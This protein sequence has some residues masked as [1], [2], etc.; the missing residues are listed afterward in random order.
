MDILDK[1][2]VAPKAQNQAPAPQAQPPGTP[3]DSEE[4]RAANSKKME[5]KRAENEKK[6]NVEAG[7]KVV[8]DTATLECVLCTNPKGT[9]KVNYDTPTIQDK[10]TATIKERGPKSLVFLGNC[11][12]SPNAAAPCTTVMNVR[13]WKDVGT[14]LSQEQPV[15]LQK[16]TIPC[17]YGGVDITITDSGQVHQPESI[18]AVGAPVP[19][20]KEKINGN[21]Y[22]YNGTFEGSVKGQKIGKET[23][24]YAC[25]GKGSEE[26]IYKSPRKLKIEH[27]EFQKVCNIIKHEGLSSEKEEYLYIAHTNYNEA[28]RVGKTMFELLNS[29]YSSVDAKDKVEMKTSEKDTI[30][31]YSR[32]GAIDALLRDV[33]EVKNDPTDNATQWDGEDFL[34]W[35]IDTDLKPDSKTKYGHNKF[36]E[37]DYIKISKSLYDSFVGKVT[38][39]RGSTLAYNS[40]HDDKCDKGNHTHKTVKEKNK[41]VY[42]I[43]NADFA[44]EDYWTT[45]N[46]YYKNATKQ[47]FGLEATRVAGY[48]IFWKKVKI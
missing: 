10:K 21:F 13:D 24:V 4:L 43:P 9:M 34:A 14:Y 36:D 47:S 19:E 46:F 32:A 44:K 29:S 16:S 2:G 45:G 12:K 37:Y 25:E 3:Q 27:S 33:D 1:E 6:D 31:L 48:T 41:A 22:N 8:I 5:E 28:K 20:S 23:D 7:L 40:I 17:T 30:S 42:A 15:L 39:R 38:G 18:D 26:D 35:G 11:K